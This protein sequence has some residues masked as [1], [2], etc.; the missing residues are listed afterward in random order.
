MN[1][2]ALNKDA[3][4]VNRKSYWVAKCSYTGMI[5]FVFGNIVATGVNAAKEEAVKLWRT[6]SPHPEPD[7]MELVQGHIIVE[8]SSA[9]IGEYGVF[10]PAS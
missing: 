1:I 3:P 8:I 7:E 5:P 6:I 2:K 9:M 4:W 10:E